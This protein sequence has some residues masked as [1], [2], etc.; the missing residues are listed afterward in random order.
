MVA[1]EE[2]AGDSGFH[3]IEGVKPSGKTAGD[4]FPAVKSGGLPAILGE[5]AVGQLGVEL[6]ESAGAASPHAGLR[7]ILRKTEVVY[8][9]EDR[10]VGERDLKAVAAESIAE[11][12][13]FKGGVGERFVE[14]R[15]LFHEPKPID[16]QIHGVEVLPGGFFW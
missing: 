7:Q 12:G 11:L 13:V 1:G 5:D 8:V 16:R 4:A 6:K 14:S 2:L 3:D 10:V 9:V 15:A